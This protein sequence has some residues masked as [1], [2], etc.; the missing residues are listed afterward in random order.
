MFPAL[1]KPARLGAAIFGSALCGVALVPHSVQAQ[2]EHYQKTNAAVLAKCGVA[3]VIPGYLP[4]GFQLAS[5]R[6]GPC[7]GRMV[8]TKPSSKALIVANSASL[9]LMAAGERLD[10]FDS[11]NPARR[12]WALS[13]LK[14][15]SMQ[16]P[17]TAKYLNAAALPV[18]GVLVL[19]AYP[20][21]GYVFNIS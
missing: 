3:L 10:L 11:G 16:I 21:A 19:V 9:E 7:P 5:F 12:C 1:S 20:R 2:Q 15:E 6:Q 17:R 4:T 18:D 14:N 8:G 13:F